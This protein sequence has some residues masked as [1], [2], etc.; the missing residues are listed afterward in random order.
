M[1]SLI[2]PFSHVSFVDIALATAG[3]VA[4]ILVLFMGSRWLPGRETQGLPMADG[5]RL[6]YRMNGLLL[7][8]LTHAL[9]LGLWKAGLFSPTWLLRHFWALFLA[10][11]LVA[12]GMTVVFWANGPERR[13]RGFLAGFWYGTELNPTWFGVEMKVFSY[14]PSL[15]GLAVLNACFAMHQW[16]TAGHLS[17][18]MVL[19][20]AM[21]QFYLL[22][23]FQFEHGMLQM[24]DVIEER[25][26]FMLVW[27]DYVVVPFFY[28]LPAWFLVDRMSPLPAWEQVALV[29]MFALGFWMFRG[30]NQQKDRFKKDPTRP[31]WGRTPRTVGGRLLI[32]GFWGIGRKLNYTGEILVYL[33]WTLPAGFDAPWPYLLP[34]WLISLLTH[35]AWR[36]EQR[37]R[38]KYGPLWDEYC[39]VAK[40]RMIPF[41]Y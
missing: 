21:T 29:G 7:L 17:D 33:A 27:G 24:Y 39:R 30:T 14:R 38:A 9:T 22:S 20:Q 35:R 31:I 25:F 16:D 5:S 41:V 10:T 12:I 18:G 1:S 36:D 2:L 15:I 8:V 32:S 34:L 19:F 4:F 6:S 23:T 11:N 40:F 13:Q 26:G 37:C 28:C 3:V